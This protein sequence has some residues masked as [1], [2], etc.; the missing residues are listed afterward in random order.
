MT[1]TFLDLNSHSVFPPTIAVPPEFNT[2]EWNARI[3]E[4]TG[5]KKNLLGCVKEYRWAHPDLKD[6]ETARGRCSATAQEFLNL[7]C[8][9]GVVSDE[10]VAFGRKAFVDGWQNGE[11]WYCRVGNIVID[12]T[13]RQFKPDSPFPYVWRVA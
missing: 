10:D 12:W 8:R 6:P 9:R 1:Y 7:L 2:P 13:Y 11:H 5:G 4:W 3:S